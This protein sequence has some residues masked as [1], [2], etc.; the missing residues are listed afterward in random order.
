MRIGQVFRYPSKPSMAVELDGLANW[1]FETASPRET[2]WKAVKLDSGINCSERLGGQAQ[3][4]PY[5][6]I[7]SSPHLFGSVVTPWEDI[8][9]PDQGYCRYFG[10]SKPGRKDASESIGNR[11]MLE[12]FVL[13][14]GDITD[15]RMAPPVLVFEAIPFDGR[16]K[17][18]VMFHGFGVITKAELVVQRSKE[19]TFPNF[20]YEIALLELDA[21]GEEFSWQWINARRD[22][23]CSTDE[24]HRLAPISWQR[25]VADGSKSIPQL[26]RNVV[27]RSLVTEKM[28]RPTAGSE[29]HTIL[30]EIYRYFSGKNHLFE[31]LAE[32][33]TAQI[34]REQGVTYSPGWITQGSG[35]GGFDFV[36][37]IDLDPSS[38]FRSSRQVVLGQA[39][40]EKLDKA[41]NGIHIARLAARL[42]RGWVGV[43][44]TTSYF[45]LPVQRE[46]LS[47]RYPVM[48]V[49]GRRLAEVIRRYLVG[50][51]ETLQVFLDRL[52]TNYASRI[53]FGDPEQVLNR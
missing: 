2:N 43:Y 15:R 17:G 40:C 25:W 38:S 52:L 30:S 51:G 23:A 4:N 49:D 53:G 32:F 35:D 19:R 39:K 22:P 1:Y 13:Q 3:P 29:D 18:Q 42:R 36:G 27:T 11:R 6:A 24:S 47:D 26:R 16:L 21:E 48:L 8:H 37:S 5:V 10:D 44:V 14:S 28:Q 41:T 33:T 20:V 9:R 7:R 45:S 34:L 46:V 12:A 50:S 31:V